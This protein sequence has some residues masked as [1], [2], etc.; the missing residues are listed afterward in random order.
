ME[1]INN[2]KEKIKQVGIESKKY[3]ADPKH[4]YHEAHG[5]LKAQIICG[6]ISIL[7]FVFLA[8]YLINIYSK[9]NVINGMKYL[10]GI[11][12]LT[13]FVLIYC[14]IVYLLFFIFVIVFLNK[15]V[16]KKSDFLLFCHKVCAIFY[17]IYFI[18]MF[19]EG[20]ISIKIVFNSVFRLFWTTVFIVLLTLYY[21]TSVKVRVYFGGDEFLKKDHYIH[22]LLDD[23]NYEK[24]NITPVVNK[25]NDEILNSQNDK[26]INA[27][28]NTTNF[29][30]LN[31]DEVKKEDSNTNNT[32]II[33]SKNSDAETI[34]MTEFLKAFTDISQ[35]DHKDDVIEN[36]I[37]KDDAIDNNSNKG[38][39]NNNVQQTAKLTTGH[40]KK[41]MSKPVAKPTQSKQNENIDRV[42][43][44]NN[45]N[46]KRNCSKKKSN[47]FVK[48]LKF[49]LST[50]IKLILLIIIVLTLINYNNKYKI[51]DVPFFK[52][53]FNVVDNVTSNLFVRNSN[54]IKNTKETAISEQVE[55]DQTVKKQVNKDQ[56][57]NSKGEN[58]KAPAK[59]VENSETSNDN[60]IASTL[61]HNVDTIEKVSHDA[62]KLSTNIKK[63]NLKG[64]K[65][66]FNNKQNAWN[67]IIN[68]KVSKNV[69]YIIDYTNPI[70]GEPCSST[71]GFD[72]NGKMIVGWGI[73]ESNNYYYFDDNTYDIGKMCTGWKEIDGHE[74]YFEPNGKLLTDSITPDGKHVDI[75]GRKIVDNNTKKSKSEGNKKSD[76]YY[77]KSTR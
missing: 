20:F 14:I 68:N 66:Q 75:N 55:K 65:W 51:T 54:N 38:V 36:D 6:Y 50:I 5:F 40:T 73:D 59:E 49:L 15:L 47:P 62:V 16:N 9:V 41:V 33:E 58:V 42:R 57:S 2:L 60:N 29:I 72:P 44:D 67:L 69:I 12:F 74:Y 34:N 39:V 76:N 63:I 24:T 30:N 3:L 53:I 19:I 71:Y 46:F 18:L 37:K 7:L 32:N 43:V 64:A 48:F 35:E 22:F 61:D 45:H 25:L 1:F 28:N 23:L 31:V 21:C 13:N 4:P 17:V 52:N 70:T 11:G 8:I 77:N 27:N 10:G 26:K 56:I